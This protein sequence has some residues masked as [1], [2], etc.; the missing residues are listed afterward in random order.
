MA[1]DI[2]NTELLAA[3]THQLGVITDNMAT[4][5]DVREIVRAVVHVEVSRLERKVDSN[6][7][8]IN[9]LDVQVTD[10]RKGLAQAIGLAM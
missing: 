6:T 5:K 7:K 10:M 3:L 1:G 2:T 8:V 9:R 4:K